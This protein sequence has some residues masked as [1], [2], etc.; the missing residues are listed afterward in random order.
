[1]GRAVCKPGE[2]K[3]TYPIRCILLF[4]ALNAC[5]AGKAVCIRYKCRGFT[6]L[7]QE[8]HSPVLSSCLVT[9]LW[10]PASN[11]YDLSAKHSP[12]SAF[13]VT[14]HPQ[15][16]DHIHHIARAQPSSAIPWPGPSHTL[17]PQ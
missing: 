11:T 17:L 6:R 3:S 8:S 15:H 4:L 2:H 14:H 10:I 16:D 12:A 1:M 13:I 5:L 9:C 7:L